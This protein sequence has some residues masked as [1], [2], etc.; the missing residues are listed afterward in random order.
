MRT[1][2]TLALA[3]V[4]AARALAAQALAAAELSEEQ[5]AA[6]A[7][8]GDPARGAALYQPC[9]GCH[10][11]DGS[12]RS[13]GAYP[14]LAGQYSTVIVK[15]LL[16]IQSGRRSNPRMEP[17][18][19]D[20]GMTPHEVADLAAYLQSLPI[21]AGGGQGPGTALERGRQLYDKDCATCHG[22][23]GEGRAREFYPMVAAQHYR[24]LL[25][26]E[27]MIRDGDRRN[28]NPDMIR[29]IK[30]YGTA[31]LEAVADYMSRLPAP[32]P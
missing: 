17:F 27:Q 19:S 26:E 5:K 12:G 25:R 22:A 4:A 32:A 14:R 9:V 30:S 2:R 23:R 3:L 20:H 28:A 29:V 13:S 11:Q 16:D 18:L 7:L 8:Q 24:Y 21:P 31:E 1:I 10:R 15:Q 6:L